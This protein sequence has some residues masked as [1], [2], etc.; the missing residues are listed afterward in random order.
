MFIVYLY[1]RRL[2]KSFILYSLFMAQD[3]MLHSFII[4]NVHCKKMPYDIWSY[5]RGA[6]TQ[7]HHDNDCAQLFAL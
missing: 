5:G 6:Y 4:R 3:Q 2:N 7:I 1:N